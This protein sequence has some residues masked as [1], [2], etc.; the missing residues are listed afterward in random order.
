LRNLDGLGHPLMD[1]LS[2][3]FRL[4]IRCP[5]EPSNAAFRGLPDHVAAFANVR[6]LVRHALAAEF[7]RGLRPKRAAGSCLSLVLEGFRVKWAREWSFPP[8]LL[9]TEF[10]P[11]PRVNPKGRRATRNRPFRPPGSRFPGAVALAAFSVVEGR[12]ATLGPP[13]TLVCRAY[14]M[15]L[16]R[17]RQARPGPVGDG[18]RN[19]CKACPDIRILSGSK[20]RR[21]GSEAL[22]QGQ[23][24]EP[25]PQ[26]LTIACLDPLCSRFAFWELD[27][28]RRGSYR[29]Q[30]PYVTN[31]AA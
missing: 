21:P 1:R 14:R 26:S 22:Y 6:F 30:G 7:L 20:G 8:F 15:G 9:G 19:P 4:K 2:C 5:S 13:F 23:R 18:S 28:P 29:G 3:R 16:R 12:E 17:S 10:V 27:P 31:R 25:H 24:D 11:R